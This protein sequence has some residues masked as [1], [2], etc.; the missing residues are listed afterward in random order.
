MKSICKLLA[1]LILTGMVSAQ[2]I[3]TTAVAPASDGCFR[4]QDGLCISLYTKSASGSSVGAATTG[5]DGVLNTAIS[6]IT[7][8]TLNPLTSAGFVFN[9]TTWDRTRSATS[10]SGT[11]GTG[12]FGAGVLG[13]DGTNYQRIGT[14][15][16][17]VLSTVFLQTGSDAVSNTN[18]QGFLF[19]ASSINGM[20]SVQSHLFNNVSWDRP[21]SVITGTDSIGTGIGAAGL[22]GQLDDT[23][24]SSV[25]ENQFGNVRIS[26]RHAILVEDYTNADPCA[27]GLAKSQAVINIT[28]ATTTSLVAVS[29]STVVYVCGFSATISQVITT[30]NTIQFEY[31]TGAACTGPVVMTGLYGGGGV[32]AGAPITVSYGGAGSTIFKTTASQGVCALTAIGAT[33]SFQGVL[34]YVQQ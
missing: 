12:L 25:T 10:A 29:G 5:A 21:R 16:G 24:P 18:A 3:N 31:G 30:P 15:T 7:G 11:T 32:T 4:S 33:G 13:F 1:A 8:A 23:S 6:S 20:L 2:I 26:P 22:V 27:S 17:G 14:S 19:G 34:T 9:G 28:T